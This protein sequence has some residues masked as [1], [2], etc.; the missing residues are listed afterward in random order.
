MERR[1]GRELWRAPKSAIN[2]FEGIWEDRDEMREGREGER[3]V[4]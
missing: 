3:A 1:R 4:S 2:I